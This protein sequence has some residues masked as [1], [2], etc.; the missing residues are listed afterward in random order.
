MGIFDKFNKAFSDADRKEIED[1]KKNNTGN[2]K[3][4]AGDY[5]AKIE[6]MEIGKSKD[7]R[8]MFK[9]MMRLVEAMHDDEK[10][11]EY[12]SHFKDKKE[13]KKPCVFM[14]RVLYGTK[15]DKNMIA[16]FEGWMENLELENPVLF[17]GD[18][19]KL[20]EDV[21]DAAEEVE[22]LEFGISYDPDAFN[23]ISIT[24]I[25]E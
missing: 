19:N 12:M 9:V 5:V 2:F 1:A 11:A 7:G 13:D 22:G 23:S 10:E 16:S 25:Y 8:P 15:N 17:M 24:D 20:A 18:F 21:L 4:P 14:N 3:T 6:N